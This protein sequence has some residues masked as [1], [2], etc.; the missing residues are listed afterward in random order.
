MYACTDLAVSSDVRLFPSKKKPET[1]KQAG[2]PNQ[3]Q[4]T[5]KHAP[6]THKPA[7]QGRR[8][9]GQGCKLRR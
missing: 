6:R 3:L 5:D 4:H 2:K 1:H 9:E 8:T 7:P